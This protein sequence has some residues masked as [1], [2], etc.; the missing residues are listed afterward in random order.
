MANCTQCGAELK[1]GI[2]FCTEC[3]AAASV[4][5]AAPAQET[6]VTPPQPQP[7]AAPTY[8]YAPPQPTPQPVY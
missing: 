4:A 2:R 1:D 7:Q 5:Q 8:N 3:G 6:P